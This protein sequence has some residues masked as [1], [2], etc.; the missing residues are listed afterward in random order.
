MGC[1]GILISWQDQGNIVII[2]WSV[3][4]SGYDDVLLTRF[5]HIEDF[6]L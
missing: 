2:M 4:F 5:I 6:G 1:V 3:R